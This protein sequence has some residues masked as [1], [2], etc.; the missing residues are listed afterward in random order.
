MIAEIRNGIVHTLLEGK[1]LGDLAIDD[2]SYG[3]EDRR[4][5]SSVVMPTHDNLP[6]VPFDL[7]A[8]RLGKVNISGIAL[9][10]HDQANRDLA[11]EPICPG[12]LS[13]EVV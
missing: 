5:E 3:N 12:D 11:L 6:Y 8:R 13:V 4:N 2:Y 9:F 7:L 1:H 10:V